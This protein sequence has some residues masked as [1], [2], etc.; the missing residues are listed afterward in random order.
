MVVQNEGELAKSV[1]ALL[2]DAAL[3]ARMG[4]KGRHIVA[5]NRGSLQ[6]LLVLLKPLIEK[7]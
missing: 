6:R 2:N 4:G 3:A 7:V 1:L 5:E